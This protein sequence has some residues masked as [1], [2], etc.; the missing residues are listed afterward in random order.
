MTDEAPVIEAS[1]DGPAIHEA[2]MVATP[3]R[4]VTPLPAAVEPLLRQAAID[5]ADAIRA[6]DAAAADGA[7]VAAAMDVA[8]VLLTANRDAARLPMV[9]YDEACE[10]WRRLLAR[11]RLRSADFDEVTTAFCVA[12]ST[13]LQVAI[14]LGLA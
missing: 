9:G 11:H 2:Q 4:T 6:D 7:I 14:G 12:L 10:L 8:G 5:V 3:A 13:N 1:G